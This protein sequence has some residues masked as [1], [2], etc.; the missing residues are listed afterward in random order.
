MRSL[1]VIAVPKNLINFE[2]AI[3]RTATCGS[4]HA[5]FPQIL[6]PG[7]ITPSRKG[8]DLGASHDLSAAA[9][10][11]VGRHGRCYEQLTLF[12]RQVVLVVDRE[13]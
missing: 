10:L 8:G 1:P 3:K 9:N 5:E 11:E 6:T 12:L 13:I 2:L 4:G 7:V